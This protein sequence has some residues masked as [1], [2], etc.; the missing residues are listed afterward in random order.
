MGNIIC[1]P[2]TTNDKHITDEKKPITN[3]NP[4]FVIVDD[5]EELMIEMGLF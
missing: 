2:S 1:I 4:I 3:T 5:E